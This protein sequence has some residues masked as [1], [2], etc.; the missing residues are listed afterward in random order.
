MDAIKCYEYLYFNLNKKGE[1]GGWLNST[2]QYLKENIFLFR[3]W[4]EQVK[5]IR[6][7]KYIAMAIGRAAEGSYSKSNL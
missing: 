2:T 1:K 5:D 7:V 3:V 4:A 6:V